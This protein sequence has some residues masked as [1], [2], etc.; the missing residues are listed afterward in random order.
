[1]VVVVALAVYPLS[2]G[3]IVWLHQHD[4]APAC[5]E[6]ALDAYCSPFDWFLH[7]APY[8]ITVPFRWYLSQWG[9]PW[10]P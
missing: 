3:P 1:V 5:A 10:I 8:P 9:R 2:I 6:M 4:A 7:K